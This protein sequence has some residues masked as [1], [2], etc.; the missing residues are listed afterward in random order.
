MEVTFACRPVTLHVSGSLCFGRSVDL[1]AKNSPLWQPQF[2][3][4]VAEIWY[5]GRVCCVCVCVCVLCVCVRA[6]VCVCVKVCVCV[7]ANWLK[8]GVEMGVAYSKKEH[9]FRMD[10]QYYTRFSGKVG[11]E[12]KDS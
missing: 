2:S 7:H 1:S 6:C 9:N 5:G 4:K 10:S 12:P 11:H 3:P 8:G